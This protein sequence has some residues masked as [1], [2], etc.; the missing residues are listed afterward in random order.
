MNMILE[1]LALI[2]A[3]LVLVVGIIG[4]VVPVLPGPVLSFA[5]L[6][7]VS[8]PGGFTLYRPR[9]LVILG[10]LALISQF[11]DNIF[12]VLAS[13]KA[14]AGKG[15]TWGSVAGMLLGMIFF[16]PLGVFIG[17]FA[18]AFLG[19]IL[20][21]KENENPLKAALGV[22]TGT[23]L[24]ILFKLSVSGVIAVYLIIGIRQLF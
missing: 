9:L 14:G 23:L 11:L 17:A 4:C 15:G 5:S 21:N 6:L 12:P 19:E 1:I 2:F 18:G 24:G 16:P 22:F 10:V 20:F 3:I 8:L 13:K 7:I